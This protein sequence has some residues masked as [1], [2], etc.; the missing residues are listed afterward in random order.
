MTPVFQEGAAISGR[1]IRSSALMFFLLVSPV[2]L[3]A[4]GAATGLLRLPYELAMLEQRLPFVFRSHMLASGLALL[5]V[6]CAIASHGLRLHKLLGRSAATLVVAGGITALPVAIASEASA[7]ARAGF[8]VQALVWVALVLLAIAAIRGGNR[9]RHIWLMLAVAAVASGAFW[10]RLASWAVVKFTLP[11]ETAY[12]LSAWLSWM[13]PLCLIYLIAR[14][15]ADDAAHRTLDRRE[16]HGFAP[17]R[18][19][20]RGARQYF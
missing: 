8:F 11:F 2:G 1:G 3:T 5:L 12:A 14:C 15:R 7:A 10:L 17:A 9:T 19:G 13:L 4:L 16:S 6:P 20:A 18:W